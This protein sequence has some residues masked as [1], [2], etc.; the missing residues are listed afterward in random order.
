MGFEFLYGLKY[1]SDWHYK[2]GTD[3]NYGIF[4]TSLRAETL[5]RSAVCV[6]DS[7]DP[8]VRQ[9]HRSCKSN[10]NRNTWHLEKIYWKLEKWWL[11]MSMKGLGNDSFVYFVC[12]FIFYQLISF[13]CWCASWLNV[14]IVHWLALGMLD[15]NY[16]PVIDVN[17]QHDFLLQLH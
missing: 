5:W 1:S 11:R 8:A 4:H 3:G 15:C 17:S 6:I 14:I 16:M 12:L 10:I 9:S 13:G 7:Q 2:V